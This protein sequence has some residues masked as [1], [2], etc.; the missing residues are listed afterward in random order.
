MP[1]YQYDDRPKNRE[2]EERMVEEY[3]ANGDS[4]LQCPN[5]EKMKKLRRSKAAS[6]RASKRKGEET[7]MDFGEF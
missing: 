2:E 7:L 5:G 1:F 3:L 6:E 4:I